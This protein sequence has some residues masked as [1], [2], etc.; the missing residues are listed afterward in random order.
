M[1][2][3]F[4]F[5]LSI[6]ATALL[7]F[8]SR[9]ETLWFP[10]EL[11]AGMG[12]TADL[13][14]FERGE[15]LPGTYS[16]NVYLN[17]KSLGIHDMSFVVADTP[18]KRAGVTDSTGLM[19]VLTQQDLI[20]AGIRPEAFG[21]QRTT[22]GDGTQPWSLGSVISQATTHF[23]FQRMRLD[24][25]IPHKWVQKQPRNWHPSE[26]WDEG[27]AAGLLNWSFSG[28]HTQGRYGG[29]DSY[30]LRLNSG[31]NIG[32]WRLRDEWTL[33]EN[34]YSSSR[35]REW[36][37]G[38]IWLERGMASLHSTLMMGDMTTDGNIFDSPGIR[39][40]GLK[41]EDTM[42]P[43]TERGYAPVIRG[44]ALSNARISIRQ[45][46]YSVYE[47]SVAPGDFAIDDINPVYSSGDLEVTVIEAD[48]STRIFTVPYATLPVLLR[49]N[50]LSYTLNAG[51]LH[52]SGR[53][54][55]RESGLLQGTL[56][57]GM[58]QDVTV[59]GGIQLTRKYQSA[60]L[61]TGINI[62]QWGAVSAD[63]T[64]AE[65]TLADDSRHHGQ[66]VR[67][68]YNRGFESTGT[69][70]QLAGYRY[71]TRGFYT[72]EE[73]QRS[74]IR[75]WRGEERRDSSGHFLPR[76]VTD[77][78]DL[79]DNRRER[80]EAN[81]SQ[82]V[83]DRSS[84]YLSGSRQTYWN[85]KGASTSLQAGFSSQLG[86]VSYSLGYSESYSPSL[87]QTDR[88]GSLSL[89][90]PLEA[91]FS[92]GGKSTYASWSIGHHSNGGMTQ[93]VGLNGTALARN[94]LNW[95]LS[96]SSLRQGNN[97]D[98]LR[99]GYRGAY[100]DVSAGYSQGRDYR[101]ISYDASGGIVVHKEGI[102][103]GQSLGHTIVLVSVPCSGVPVE[104][105]YG[106]RTDWHGYA[107][108]PWIN[109]Y[110]ENRI[111]LDVAHL[112]EWTEVREPVKQVVPTKGA[113]VSV[114]FAAKTGLRTLITLTKDGKPLP[115]GTTVS[116]GEN[117]GIVGDGGQ[118]F[119]SGLEQ[120]GSL[121]A[122]WG[123]DAG[124]SCRATWAIGKT[125]V[126]RPLTRISAICR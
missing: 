65:S 26:L 52:N 22:R 8:Y 99:V 84:L 72:L 92:G 14:R 77:W 34:R 37:H 25:S 103:L 70:F 123:R 94:N 31:V 66:S 58:S 71:S 117:N 93:Q 126:R 109:E 98:S 114:K 75:G 18:E 120:N 79:K 101:Q 12:K 125:D 69:T 1:G 39:G 20:T 35:T 54:D 110:R 95:S 118:V 30:F 61:G 45:N 121:I 64:H 48:G 40:I 17:Q 24:I 97:S 90:V 88:N 83:M 11:V 73:S 46:G 16:V 63:I 60:A 32:P 55:A 91:L 47:T 89:S 7:C 19:A 23:D 10:P 2:G 50:R 6:L 4:T 36:R 68:L 28:T 21:K 78:Y 87:R 106:V 107:I 41:T 33:S 96:Q 102:T 74:F 115:F 56:A 27:I 43:E 44:T 80:I 38:R 51:W 116:A 111:A 104:S 122:Q 82:R 59:Y 9:A 62:G 49:E 85:H 13:S 57:R 29:S 119:L 113:V 3:L 15:Q 124:Q 100:G 53:H 67:F 112:D 86:L 76:P 81:V 42:Y 108:Q 5:R 105:G